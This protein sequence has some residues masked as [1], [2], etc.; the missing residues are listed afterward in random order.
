MSSAAMMD[1]QPGHFCSWAR[2]R[3][4]LRVPR[5][6]LVSRPNSTGKV[7]PAASTASNARMHFS[8]VWQ[9]LQ[10][11]GAVWGQYFGV[12]EVM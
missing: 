9:V 11:V 12:C 10:N 1:V 8:V 2:E 4:P 5:G 6:T 3:K 7:I